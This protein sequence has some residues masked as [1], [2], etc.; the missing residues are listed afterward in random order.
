MIGR[1]PPRSTCDRARLMVITSWLAPNRDTVQ[2]QAAAL[3]ARTARETSGNLAIITER[4]NSATHTSHLFRRDVDFHRSII[5][6]PNSLVTTARKSLLLETS[7]ESD[8]R[9]VKQKSPLAQDRSSGICS[10]NPRL[11][12]PGDR[13]EFISQLISHITSSVNN[14][15]FVDFVT[16]AIILI[17]SH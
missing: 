4:R 7:A 15:P 14:E 17:D 6:E 5:K 11:P 10:E 3:S 13:S 12:M 8:R 2:K 16:P 9:R 1:H